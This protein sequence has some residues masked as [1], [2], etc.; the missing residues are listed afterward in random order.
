MPPV[1]QSPREAPEPFNGF[2][3]PT[4]NTTYTPNQF[5]DVCLPHCSRG[6]VRVVA[7]MLR[8]TL[9]W[10]DEEGNPQ[11]VE[12]LATY[13]HFERA[14]ISRSMIRPA[15]DEAIKG[16]FVRCVREPQQ[17]RAG[18]AAV[19]GMYELKWDERPE[20][21]KDPRKFRGFFA[22]EGNRTY[23]PNQFFDVVIPKEK[24]AVVKVVGAVIR[25][26]IGFQN[27]WGHRMQ[28]VAL[29][30]QHIQN[31]SRI[32]NRNTISAAIQ[33]ALDSNYIRLVE[34]GKF[35]R[36]AGI[37]SAAAVYAIKW[38]YGEADFMHSWKIVPEE[39]DPEKRF[40]KRTGNGSKS[41]P[42]ERFE[43]R[44][45]LEITKTNKTLKQQELSP[46]AAASFE[47]LKEAG[48][49]ATAAN[50]IARKY[51]FDR[52]DR[53]IQWIDQR[54]ATKNRLGM[55]RKAI[56]EDWP[57][58]SAGKLGQPKLAAARG[59]TFEEVLADSKRRLIDSSPTTP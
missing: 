25:F 4:S 55:L 20:Y 30:Y 39:N 32:G 17:Q 54:K 46:E 49:D 37:T 24:L 27:K 13:D 29:S 40:E 31:Y 57:A 33:R 1:A 6:C 22:G 47:K 19:S 34:P 16:H 35:D 38:L 41:V 9:G 36:N 14:G 2:T 51:P 42:A 10:S 56:M 26:S 8:L 53:Q 12:H 45:D 3:R 58:P 43:K 5:F 15:L 59:K 21:I 18:Q 11:R 28:K 23:I 44:T 52:I 48:F 7:L 50:S